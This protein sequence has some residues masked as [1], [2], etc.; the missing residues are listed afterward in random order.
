MDIPNMIQ[1]PNN[2]ILSFQLCLWKDVRFKLNV[3]A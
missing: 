3:Q 2:H 1:T